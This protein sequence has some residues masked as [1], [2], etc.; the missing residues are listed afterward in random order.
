MRCDLKR[1]S[2]VAHP[3]R[4]CL[5]P[6]LTLLTCLF[7]RCVTHRPSC[8]AP[9]FC[10]QL[11]TSMRTPARVSLPLV[12]G[13]SSVPSSPG[14]AFIPAPVLGPPTCPAT[15]LIRRRHAHLSGSWPLARGARPVAHLRMT[16]DSEALSAA[17]VPPSA[18]PRLVGVGIIGCGRIGQV[19]ARA[20]TALPGASLVAVADP[21][22]PFGLAVAS[23]FSTRWVSDWK[24]LVSNPDVDAVVIG[25]P[26]PFHAEQIK[27][28]A[29]AGKA[30][31]CEKPISNDLSTIDE[32]IQVR[33]SIYA[34]LVAIYVLVLFVLTVTSACGCV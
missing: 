21:F 9:V 19:H 32:C 27:A 29:A 31:F 6:M 16:S 14:M 30:V 17:A 5:L 13:Q 2:T 3:V 11:Y 15:V 10:S 7:I 28:C 23:E 34:F 12:Q 20:T 25:S 4:Q 8:S 33:R 18:I 26:T 24:E 1:I 22:E